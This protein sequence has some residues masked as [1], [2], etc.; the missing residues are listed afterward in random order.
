MIAT[1]KQAFRGLHEQLSILPERRGTAFPLRWDQEF[2]DSFRREKDLGEKYGQLFRYFVT[3]QDVYVSRYKSRVFYPGAPS[4]HG[5]KVDGLEG[6]S[7]MLPLLSVWIVSGREPAPLL[8][9]GRRADLRAMIKQGVRQGV[10]PGPGFWGDPL[11][12]GQWVVEA[13]DIALSAWLLKQGR[14]EFLDPE[15]TR[16]LIRWL[17]RAASR[18]CC[19][20]NWHLF[21][22]MIDAVMLTLGWGGDP[23]RLREHFSRIK[24]FY[25]EC[26]WFR[27]GAGGEVDLYNAWGFHYSLF[28]LQSVMPDFEAGFIQEA[29]KRFFD[30]YK[31]L[32]TPEGAPLLGRSLV[33]RLALSVP[34]LIAAHRGQASCGLA[35]RA[36][37]VTWDYYLEHG[38]LSRGR[39]TQ[40]IFSDNP[41][42]V[43]VYSAP[44]SPL[45]GLRSFIL[46]LLFRPET[47]LWACEP[48][49]LPVETEDFEVRVPG[50]GWTIKGDQASGAVTIIRDEGLEPQDIP[51]EAYTLRNW[52]KEK[53]TAR[54]ARPRNRDIK[55]KLK[56]YSS[57]KDFQDSIFR[58]NTTLF[59]K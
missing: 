19:D 30:S 9:D 38:A 31:Y 12:R 39:L 4:E 40:G 10:M 29:Q 28:W 1:I 21:I 22:C 8:L 6:F 35:R 11:D 44:A 47:G 34:Y 46:A 13:H 52:F 43:D 51:F 14:E 36:F 7:R 25:L 41:A 48:E 53:I 5:L 55:Y 37:D 15:G 33:Y 24:D 2:L 58:N 23:V 57:S 20:S 26:G 32:I 45:W 17:E 56:A 54:A 50:P 49:P 42:I 16:A 3:G 59:F 27:D 18:L